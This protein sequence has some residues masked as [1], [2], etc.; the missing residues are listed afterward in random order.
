LHAVPKVPDATREAAR[1]LCEKWR[2]F[3][4]ESRRSDASRDKTGVERRA[5]L[6]ASLYITLLGSEAVAAGAAHEG[7]SLDEIITGTGVPA[8]SFLDTVTQ[9]LSTAAARDWLRAVLPDVA[10]AERQF[11]KQVLLFPLDGRDWLALRHGSRRPPAP[12]AAPL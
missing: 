1:A 3:A 4:E 9:I 6:A 8:L 10:A 12:G 2:V 5:D 7:P 11:K